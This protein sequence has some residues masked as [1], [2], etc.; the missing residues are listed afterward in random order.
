MSPH[1]PATIY[2]GA[3]KVFKSTDRGQSW[4]AISPDLTSATDRDGAAA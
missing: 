3:N 1:D 4:T 2:V